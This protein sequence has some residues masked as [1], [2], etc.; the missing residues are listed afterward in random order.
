MKK[1]KTAFKFKWIN[2]KNMEG[3]ELD[4]DLCGSSV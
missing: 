4:Y 2:D 3:F 1:A